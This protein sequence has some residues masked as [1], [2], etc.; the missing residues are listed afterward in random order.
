MP[1]E[2]SVSH[3]S[4]F[5]FSPDLRIHCPLIPRNSDT[6]ANAIY[7]Q[8]FILN[9]NSLTTHYS[10]IAKTHNSHV[11]CMV[12]NMQLCRGTLTANQ[13]S[14]ERSSIS[15]SP[16]C[17]YWHIQEICLPRARTDRRVSKRSSS[18][19]HHKRLRTRYVSRWGNPGNNGWAF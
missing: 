7:A 12:N 1:R 11:E 13:S 18:Q 16:R 17:K 15:M 14:D 19:D 2:H 9:P 3:H 4:L 6:S 8:I 5:S 10:A